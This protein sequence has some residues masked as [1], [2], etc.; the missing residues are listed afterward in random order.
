MG[1]DILFVEIIFNG[2]LDAL[3]IDL[4]DHVVGVLESSARHPFVAA[5]FV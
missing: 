5:T 3:L 2:I 4:I 1:N